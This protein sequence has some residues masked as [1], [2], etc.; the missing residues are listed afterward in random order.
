MPWRARAPLALALLAA[1]LVLAVL[2]ASA[3]GERDFPVIASRAT[4]FS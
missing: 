4:D 3:S 1:A 2:A